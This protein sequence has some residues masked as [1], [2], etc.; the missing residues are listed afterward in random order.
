MNIYKSTTNNKKVPIY[1]FQM[2]RINVAKD[3][4]H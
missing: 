2:I 3:K 4:N 1:V